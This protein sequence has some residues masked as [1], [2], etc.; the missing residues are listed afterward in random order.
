MTY[1][2]IHYSEDTSKKPLHS[3]PFQ[4]EIQAQR[5]ADENVKSGTYDIVDTRSRVWTRARGEVLQKLTERTHDMDKGRM[6]VYKGITK[7]DEDE[8]ESSPK[9]VKPRRRVIKGK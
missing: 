3:G 4:M 8:T 5:F 1:W 2:V 9:R 7:F 6:R